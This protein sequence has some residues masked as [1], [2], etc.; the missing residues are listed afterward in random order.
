M[1]DPNHSVSSQPRPAGTAESADLTLLQ[2]MG[3]VLAAG[4]GVQSKENKVRDF[5]RGKP[6]HFIL[7]GLIFTAALLVSLVAVVTLVV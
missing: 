1:A 7:A 5:T 2:V 6:L 3:S 4:F